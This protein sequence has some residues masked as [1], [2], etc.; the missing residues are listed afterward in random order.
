MGK[1]WVCHNKPNSKRQSMEWKHVD[2]LVK[3]MFR[4]EGHAES[5]LG[6]KKDLSLMIF[7][8]KCFLLPIH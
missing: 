6:Q 8:K 4:K 2:T 7:L 1:I 5:F 3:K